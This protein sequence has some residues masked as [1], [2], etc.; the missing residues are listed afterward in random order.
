MNKFE[1]GAGEGIEDNEPPVEIG[2]TI[3]E[4]SEPVKN[5]MESFDRIYYAEG[6]VTHRS[7]FARTPENPG[8]RERPL[9]SRT[10]RAELLRQFKEAPKGS[11]AR[12]KIIEE[13]HLRDEIIEQ[14]MNQRE[15]T[16]NS[17][18]GEL[19]ARVVDINPPE[20]SQT[21]ETKNMPPIFYIQGI[22]NDIECGSAFLT[23]LALQGRRVVSVGYP[24]SFMGQTTQEFADAVEEDEGFGPHTEFYKTVID[25]LFKE[26]EEIELYGY[27]TGAPIVSGILQEK[28]YQERTKNAALLFP[29]ASVDQTVNSINLGVVHDMGFIKEN[30]SAS[31]NLTVASKRPQEKEQIKL[32]KEIMGSLMKKIGKANE[33]WRTARVEEGGNIVVISGEKDAITKSA[34]MNEEF[35][36]GNDQIKAAVLPDAY[37]S[38]LQIK[39]DRVVA[40]ISELEKK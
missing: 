40:E 6:T 28:K 7:R 18:Y 17:K 32:R 30:S 3:K 11:E 22:S 24:E 26:G 34:Q 5:L 1:M 33:S 21:E 38:T 13:A 20:G 16:I 9:F 14:Y 36:R 31:L 35:K 12:E 4:E 27:S 37:H 8:G 19:K 2:E 23:E 25:K 10:D 39:P 29:A 15:M